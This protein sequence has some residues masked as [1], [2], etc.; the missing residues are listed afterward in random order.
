MSALV[1]LNENKAMCTKCGGH[2]CK[3]LPGFTHPSD[4]GKTKQGVKQQ[5]AKA[6]A[7]GKFLHRLV[8]RRCRP[9]WWFGACTNGSSYNKKGVNI[10]LWTVAGVENAP[11]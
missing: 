10:K 7:T 3:T 2:C 11:C 5:A 1:V 8:G 9:I 4:W 6:L